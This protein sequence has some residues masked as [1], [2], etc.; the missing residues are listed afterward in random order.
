MGKNDKMC[1]VINEG[2]HAKTSHKKHNFIT[3][4]V[5]ISVSFCEA[6]NT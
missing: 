5:H 4:E 6:V 3:S 1:T 2:V